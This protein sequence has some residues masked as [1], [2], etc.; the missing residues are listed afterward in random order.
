MNCNDIRENL[1]ELLT[2]GPASPE[3]KAHV[4]HCSACAQ[5]LESLRKTMSLLDEWESPEPSPYFLTRLK[6]HAREERETS[7]S[8]VWTR[9]RRPALAL[10]LAAVLAVRGVSFPT[11]RTAGP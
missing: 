6:A 8:A 2:D 11:L 10:S 3:I 4:T 9:L 7:R 5:E 1:I